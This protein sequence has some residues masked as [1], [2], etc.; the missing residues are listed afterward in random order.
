[1]AEVKK[2]NFNHE[3]HGI[4]GIKKNMLD[5]VNSEYSVVNKMKLNELLPICETIA[6]VK[7]IR[8]NPSN[9]ILV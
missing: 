3:T 4:H 7:K 1:L 8:I 6:A 9:K 2:K 5:S